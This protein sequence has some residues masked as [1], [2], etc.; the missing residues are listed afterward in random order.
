MRLTT[1]ETRSKRGDLIQFYKA[2]N[3]FDRIEWLNELLTVERG[4]NV[5]NGGVCFHREPVNIFT[6]S[7]Q[8]FINRVILL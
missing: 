5:R 8:F 1:L 4:V 2:L 3:A 6:E 7:D